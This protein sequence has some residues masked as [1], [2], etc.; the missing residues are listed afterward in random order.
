MARHQRENFLSIR[1]HIVR[2]R[3]TALPA[4]QCFERERLVAPIPSPAET[5]EL[6]QPSLFCRERDRTAPSHCDSIARKLPPPFES[7]HRGSL[8]RKPV[9]YTSLK[10]PVSSDM[11]ASHP[12][13]RNYPLPEFLANAASYQRRDDRQTFHYVFFG[14]GLPTIRELAGWLSHWRQGFAESH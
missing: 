7:R 5:F 2:K 4:R 12:V 6:T 11:W 1:S 13:G 8:A 9:T 3:Q 14:E 10:P